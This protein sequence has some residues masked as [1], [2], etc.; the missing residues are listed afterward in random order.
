[1]DEYFACDGIN[2][3]G[4]SR[5]T[6]FVLALIFIFFY[7]LFNSQYAFFLSRGKQTNKQ[8][9]IHRRNHRAEGRRAARVRVDSG[10]GRE[11]LF[12]W[13]DP[14]LFRSDAHLAGS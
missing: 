6:F 11:T 13:R 9:G 5:F 4:R 8:T 3:A 12:F 1:M 2:A 14:R 10:S 7:F